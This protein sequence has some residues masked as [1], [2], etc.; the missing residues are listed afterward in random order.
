VRRPANPSREDLSQNQGGRVRA[1]ADGGENA[2]KETTP[3]LLSGAAYA[4]GEEDTSVETGE[5]ALSSS[6]VF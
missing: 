3:E 1:G 2:A 5:V 4:I 6:G